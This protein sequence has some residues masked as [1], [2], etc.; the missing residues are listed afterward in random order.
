MLAR[1][2][3]VALL[4]GLASCADIPRAAQLNADTPELTIAVAQVPARYDDVVSL[5]WACS[6]AAF[7]ISLSVRQLPA[8]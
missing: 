8:C 4:A 3:C 5:G 7:C 6:S 2:V 1:V